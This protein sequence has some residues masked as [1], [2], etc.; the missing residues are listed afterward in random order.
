MIHQNPLQ[1]FHFGFKSSI[2]HY[3]GMKMRGTNF[4]NFDHE[5]HKIVAF[6]RR[7]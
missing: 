1:T 6:A 2:L 7:K 5:D 4:K 3:A